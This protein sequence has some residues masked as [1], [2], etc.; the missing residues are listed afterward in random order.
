MFNI[1][2]DRR[3]RP[4]LADSGATFSCISYEYFVN[5]PYLKKYFVP[6]KTYGTAINGSDVESVGDVKLQFQLNGTPMVATC[7]VT[8]G[9]MDE[10]ILGW[11]WMC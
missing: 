2:L 3:R 10:V 4:V 5:S 8:K 9:L 1:F 6:N 7:K 11:D